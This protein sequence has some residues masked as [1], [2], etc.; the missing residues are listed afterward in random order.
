VDESGE[1]IQGSKPKKIRKGPAPT[2]SPALSPQEVVE[3]QFESFSFGTFA[4]VE[5][6]HVFLSRKVVEEK[7]IDV[8]KFRKVMEGSSFDGIVGCAE[9]TVLS[10]TYDNDRKDIAYVTL[11]V[12]SKPIPGCVRVT[13]VADQQGISWP[14]YYK[15]TLE[16]VPDDATENAGC[17]M[18]LDMGPSTPPVEVE[19]LEEMKELLAAP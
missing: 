18:L 19:G 4:G 14:A 16:R 9:Y 13:G 10:T 3:A 8:K 7:G 11:R 6:A 5:E 12:L 15:W 17:W 1:V 2:P